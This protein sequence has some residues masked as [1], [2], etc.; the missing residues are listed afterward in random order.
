MTDGDRGEGVWMRSVAQSGD[1]RQIAGEQDYLD[2]GGGGDGR[3]SGC[4]AWPNPAL[5]SGEDLDVATGFIPD[6]AKICCPPLCPKT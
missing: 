5:G 2:R 3:R 4:G 6:P 1:G